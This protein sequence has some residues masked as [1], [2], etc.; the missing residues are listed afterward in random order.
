MNNINNLIKKSG[1]TE[2]LLKNSP[3]KWKHKGFVMLPHELLFN[4]KIGHS[5]LLVFWVLTAHLF[6]GKSYCFPSIEKLEKETRLSK[7]TVINGIKQLE[8]AEYLEVERK[9]GKTNKY[10]LKVKI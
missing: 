9:K 1:Y 7:H 5:G 4:E 2:K 8:M 6:R 10:F 3:I